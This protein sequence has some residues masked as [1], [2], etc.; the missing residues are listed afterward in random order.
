MAK[1]NA[2]E[3]SELNKI[4]GESYFNLKNTTKHSICQSIKE[5]GNGT[6]QILS[7]G[8]RVL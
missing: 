7:I 2:I 3:K 1:S 6:I 4:I 8:L 5:K